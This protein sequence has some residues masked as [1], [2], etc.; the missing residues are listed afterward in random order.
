[1]PTRLR[2]RRGSRLL[3]L[4]VVA[5]AAT[6]VAVA[7]A[8][9]EDADRQDTGAAPTAAWKGLVGGPRPEVTVGQRTIVLL[10]V[11][12]LA[13]RLALAGGRATEARLKRWQTIAL[14][15]QEQL[16]AGLAAEGV[17]I[18]PEYRYTRVLSGFSAALDPRGIALLERS[19]G[20]RAVY[21]VR[22]AYPA[23][24][25]S[26]LLERDAAAAGSVYR[27]EARLPGFDGRGVTVALLDTGVDSGHRYFGT[28]VLDGV[29]LV[30]G[31]DSAEAEPHPETGELERHGTQLAGLVAGANG[32]VGLSGVA[33]RATIL[34]LRVA[35][36]QRDSRGTFSVYSRTDQLIAGLERAVDP[37]DDGDTH[38]AARI[39][40]IGVAEPFGA[41]DDSPAAQAVAGA[42][43]H[44]TLVV[45]PAGNDGPAGVQFGSISGPGGSRAALTVGAA[46]LRSGLESV[47][48]VLRSGLR[49]VL[50]RRLALAG[51]VAPRNRVVLPLAQPALPET[52]PGLEPPVLELSVFFDRAGFSR[53][54]GRAALVPA[55]ASPRDS[56]AAAA[57]AGAGAVVLYG[58]E[59]PA[60]AVGLSDDVDVPVV[61]VSE[62]AGRELARVLRAGGRVTVSLGAP[63][64]RSV[65]RGVAAFS[66]RGLAFDGRLK[67][68]LSAPGVA[69]LT[70]DPGRNPDAS[71]RYG[72]ASGSSAAAA[73]VAGAA[74]LL[75]QARPS[76]DA[77]ALKGLL[78]GAARP[79]AGE[80]LNAQGAGLVDIGAAAAAEVAAAP[81]TLTFPPAS[82][83]GWRGTRLLTLRN[84]STR[85]VRLAIA[86]PRAGAVVVAASPRRLT[87]EPG[88]R[89][90]VFVTAR[91]AFAPRG[92][93]AVEGALRVTT[94]GG[95]VFRVPWAVIP[96]RPQRPLIGDVEISSTSFKPS[97]SA[98]AVLSLTAGRVSGSE[99]RPLA[100]FDL[101]LW[102]GARRLGVLVRL[103]DLLPGRYAFGLTG[104]DP[105]GE[106]L[107][108]GKY[109]LLLKAFPTDD[110]QPA[111]RSLEFRIR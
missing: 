64:G 2:D 73:V 13:E 62:S 30:D 69:V 20:V 84:V 107:E 68:D 19:K 89:A 74:A 72:T 51:A 28:R 59:L 39:A 75:A 78:V 91:L 29:D 50:D 67:P 3:L 25:S 7:S 109:R 87:L 31:D 23:T 10:E 36:W 76:L 108:P 96:A 14:A 100:R 97:D 24:V 1:M 70:S 27:A 71:P 6:A 17:R 16:I 35:G 18:R 49:T 38:D 60:G 58:G 43:R 32:P 93:G 61:A 65:G 41:F 66:S 54:A 95:G 8:A 33:P 26:E 56:A 55:G 85:P 104:R 83:E 110:P 92:T 53:V 86:T 102:R 82:G 5:L 9:G 22:T 42:L 44:D 47:R 48:V 21:P 106:E 52:P 45:A 79:I 37:N 88:G 99:L 98:P 105:E 4:G 12:S 111:T 46:D 81:A 11:P 80:D 57:R 101:E 34:P 103:R 15:A 77:V 94:I 90:H 63:I 40:L